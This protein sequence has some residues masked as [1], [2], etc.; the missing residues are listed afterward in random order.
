M[1]FWEPVFGLLPVVFAGS[2]SGEARQTLRQ[3]ADEGSPPGDQCEV[4]FWCPQQ[5]LLLGT[6]VGSPFGGLCRVS[7]R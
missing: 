4:S 3:G 7:F 5:G 2:P 1:Y 6:D